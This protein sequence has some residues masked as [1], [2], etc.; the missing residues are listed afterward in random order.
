[1]KLFQFE[2]EIYLYG[3]L[4]IPLLLVLRIII[5]YFTKKRLLLFGNKELIQK[6]SPNYSPLRKNLKFSIL[7]LA[8][9][10]LLIGIANPQIGSKL[11]KS[12]RQGVDLLLAVDISNSM[13]AQDIKPNRLE[14]SKMAISQLIDKLNGDRIGVIVFAGKAYPQLPITTDYGAAKMF[15]S[16]VNTDYVNVQGTSLASAIELG[17]ES[18]QSNEEKGNSKK[19]NKAI[20]IITDGEDH[21]EG[22]IDAAQE[23]VKQ[24]IKIYTIGMGLAE[25][26]P[27]PVYSN[28]KIT[29]F[30]KDNQ[31]N[32]IITK[33]NEEILQKIAKEGKGS[34]VRANNTKVG[35][36]KIFEEINSL[37]K[38]EIEVRTFNDYEDRF[39]IPI[40]IVL[41][42]IIIELLIPNRKSKFSHRF[43]QIINRKNP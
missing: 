30:K 36:D 42:F 3:L 21:E 10:F 20:V 41:I 29:G 1:M 43:N 40:L 5:Q 32:T 24:N 15:L 23:A 14:R 27:I 28:G 38:G 33:L 25:G 8:L 35:L 37:E 2:N 17:I 22:A 19:K 4:V 12:K 11:E 13:L 18:L 7:L 9:F 31:G 26:S 16:S 39:Q 34:Y 6:L